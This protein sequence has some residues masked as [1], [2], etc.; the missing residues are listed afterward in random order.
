[1][2]LSTPLQIFLIIIVCIIILKFIYDYSQEGF[3]DSSYTT[4]LPK[5]WYEYIDVIYYINLDHR[6]DRQTEFLD[7]MTKMGV[8]DTKLVRVPGIYKPGQGDLGCSMSHLATIQTFLESGHSN[9]IIFEDDFEFTQE[10][11]NINI[12]FKNIFENNIPYDVCMLSSNTIES[13]PTEWPFLLRIK[14]AQ[15]TSGYMISK[16][17]A[18]TLM[19]NFQEG[20]RLL[21]ES[22]SSG[23]DTNIQAPYCIDQYW[24]HLQPNHKWY[25][26]QPKLG[27]QRDSYSDI[28]QGVVH[29]TV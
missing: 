14:S 11:Q 12:A 5:S 8:P 18:P 6:K 13:E 22:Y 27:K 17:F 3:Q 24:K 19:K 23:K 28:Q 21:E 4:P 20:S 29:M 26:F 2:I 9:C 1:M 10:L 7:E 15:T 25:V 16:Q